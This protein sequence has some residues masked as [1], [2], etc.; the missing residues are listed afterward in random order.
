MAIK[1][2][3]WRFRTSDF[4]NQHQT[5]EASRWAKV[6]KEPSDSSL[7]KCWN[8]WMWKVTSQ[9]EKPAATFSQWGVFSSHT[10]PK[11]DIPSQMV[12]FT[13][14]RW[15][16]STTNS[17]YIVINSKIFDSLIYSNCF[18]NGHFLPVF[19]GLDERHKFA[20]PLIQEMIQ[21]DPAKRLGLDK[22]KEQLLPLVL[23]PVAPSV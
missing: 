22:V 18:V 23:A 10:W 4:A 16:L 17:F 6:L 20:L 11:A 5:P 15:I 8:S 9:E 2:S 12:L 7:R 21:P 1:R 19:L 3:C 13:Q 14:F